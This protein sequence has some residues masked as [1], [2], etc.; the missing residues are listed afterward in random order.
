MSIQRLFSVA[1]D[2]TIDKMDAGHNAQD[3]YVLLWFYSKTTKVV[4]C[5]FL[6]TGK[7]AKIVDETIEYIG[8]Y[9]DFVFIRALPDSNHPIRDMRVRSAY[10]QSHRGIA[11]LQNRGK[12]HYLPLYIS[13]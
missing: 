7:G 1:P 11:L 6:R 8:V 12:R 4:G 2:F 5:F 13:S 10:Q 3:A 9:D